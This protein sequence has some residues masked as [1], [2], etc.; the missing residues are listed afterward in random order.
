MNKFLPSTGGHSFRLDD[1][2]LMQDSFFSGFDALI[3]IFS[4]T[5][6]CIVSGIVVDTSGVNVLYTDGY[7]AI[8][9]EIF[10]VVAGSFTKSVNPADILYFKPVQTAIIPSPVTY[11]DTTAKNVHFSRTAIL[12]YKEVGDTDG[13][14]YFKTLRADAGNIIDWT[15][16]S[17]TQLSDFF[18]NTGLGINTKAGWAICN[19]IHAPDLRG[20]YTAMGTNVPSTGSPAL[21]SSL[22]GLTPTVGGKFGVNKAALT[23]ANLPA[24]NLTVNDPG[25]AHGLP[26]DGGGAQ[27]RQ[28]LLPSANSDEG[29]SGSNLTAPAT[30]GITVHTGGT[31]DP[32]D[33]R[34]PTYYV[35][36][37]MRLN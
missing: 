2:M 34:P 1:L 9:G 32:I 16:P 35:Y 15:L 20:F 37:I 4:G 22:S 19:G 18:D 30:T 12:K 11:E 13:E 6:S 28:S 31:G 25:H 36:K 10:Q 8:K 26:I 17:G 33:K 7:V 3:R 27:D 14:E 29:L 23:Q 21:D 24:V 5:G